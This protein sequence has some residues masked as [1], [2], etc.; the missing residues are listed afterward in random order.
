MTVFWLDRGGQ[1]WGCPCGCFGD[2]TPALAPLCDK[3]KPWC[4]FPASSMTLLMP[5]ECEKKAQAVCVCS[6]TTG[7]H[8]QAERSWQGSPGC[9]CP[10]R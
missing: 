10:D 4:F 3:S 8:R 6:G 9:S 7:M 1:P 2:S 5:L